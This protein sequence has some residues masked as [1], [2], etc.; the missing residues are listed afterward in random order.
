MKRREF[1]KAMA[2]ACAVPLMPSIAIAT[3]KSAIIC[4]P[5]ALNGITIDW[6]AKTIKVDGGGHTIWE[7]YQYCMEA[8]KD[9]LRE[10][11]IGQQISHNN[12][13]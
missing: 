2:A 4:S 3:G 8:W 6:G 13:G 12:S 11:P 5:D 9:D 1:L 7:V 10:I